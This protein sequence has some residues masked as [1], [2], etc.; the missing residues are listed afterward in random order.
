MDV[1]GLQ[2]NTS[3]CFCYSF[4]GRLIKRLIG[5]SRYHAPQLC[6]HAS[7]WHPNVQSLT[8]VTAPLWSWHSGW[9]RPC[10]RS[11][12]ATDRKKTRPGQ[13]GPQLVLQPPTDTSAAT[14]T[15]HSR[16]VHGHT[17]S[18]Q[19][20]TQHEACRVR[21]WAVALGEELYSLLLAQPVTLRGQRPAC[22]RRSSHAWL[23]LQL[24]PLRLGLSV[25][26][27]D[28]GCSPIYNK[29]TTMPTDYTMHDVHHVRL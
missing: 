18:L 5:R 10:Q 14:L 17:P 22:S 12:L 20:A 25:P 13:R 8:V 4:V 11:R 3:L 15:L 24:A 27:A 23:W 6:T 9:S 28:A 19:R 29:R 7:S 1:C 2:Q 26:A 21:P 16:H